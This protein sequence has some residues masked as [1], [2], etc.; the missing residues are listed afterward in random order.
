MW[1][2]VP[3][4][5][6]GARAGA[7]WCTRDA[8]DGPGFLLGCF[9]GLRLRGKRAKCPCFYLPG[10]RAG[11]GPDPAGTRAHGLRAHLQLPNGSS[12][13]SRAPLCFNGRFSTRKQ[14]ATGC[15]S[16]RGRP[17]GPLAAPSDRPSAPLWAR[18]PAGSCPGPAWVS[19]GSRLGPA[20]VPPGS[21]SGRALVPGTLAKT[22]LTCPLCASCRPQLK[23]ALSQRPPHPPD[24]TEAGKA[25]RCLRWLPCDARRNP[26]HLSRCQGDANPVSGMLSRSPFEIHPVSN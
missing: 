6:P 25:R 2:L 3:C 4:D 10:T 13:R 22:C 19:P 7:A 23:Q 11:P 16:G 20:W 5:A 15:A 9:E 17:Q 8:V 1:R 24:S 12:G 21:R 26:L 14:A 18:V